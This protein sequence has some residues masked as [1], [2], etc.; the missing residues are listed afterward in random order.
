MR[1]GLK[2]LLKIIKAVIWIFVIL[3]VA[4]TLVQRLSDNKLTL[5]PTVTEFNP[6]QP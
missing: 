1:K 2:I 6:L 3:L 5:L 4:I